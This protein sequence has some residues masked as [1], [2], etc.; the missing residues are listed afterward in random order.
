MVVVAPVAPQVATGA[1]AVDSDEELGSDEDAPLDGW[2]STTMDTRHMTKLT[3]NI[4]RHKLCLR[5]TES[6]KQSTCKYQRNPPT[7]V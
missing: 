7:A 1:M 3:T 4:R 6:P 2:L 5:D